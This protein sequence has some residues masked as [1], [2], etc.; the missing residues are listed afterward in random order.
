MSSG[1]KDD[2]AVSG[3][4]N[5]NS[6]SA[7]LQTHKHQIYNRL[8]RMI[9]DIEQFDG[10]SPGQSRFWSVRDALRDISDHVKQLADDHRTEMAAVRETAFCAK[11]NVSSVLVRGAYLARLAV[12]AQQGPGHCVHVEGFNPTNIHHFNIPESKHQESQP[13]EKEREAFRVV[14]ECCFIDPTPALAWD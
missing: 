5:Y 14:G 8:D 10:Q 7:A 2:P 11:H 1:Y 4:L 13:T 12:A 9:G 6:K 3:S